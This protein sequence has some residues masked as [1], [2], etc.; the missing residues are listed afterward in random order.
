MLKIT[1]NPHLFQ[2]RCK[3]HDLE[4]INKFCQ[5]FEECFHSRLIKE[6]IKPTEVNTQH[7]EDIKTRSNGALLSI[8]QFWLMRKSIKL[9]NICYQEP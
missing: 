3:N 5:Y 4:L 9:Q 6:H 2:S 7:H 1:S 8:F